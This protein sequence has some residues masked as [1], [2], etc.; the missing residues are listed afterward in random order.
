[1]KLLLISL[2]LL[3][4]SCMMHKQSDHSKALQ[5]FTVKYEKALRNYCCFER[6]WYGG[7]LMHDIKK[8][9]LTYGIITDRHDIAAARITA[10]ECID[11]FTNMINT[12]EK[13]HPYLHEHPF[14]SSSFDL[15]L[16]LRNL[17]GSRYTGEEVKSVIFANGKLY[18]TK[19]NPETGFS[20]DLHEETY[21]EAKRLVEQQ[22][23]QTES[24]KQEPAIRYY[25]LT[26]PSKLAF[27]TK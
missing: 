25:S 3:L 21:E 9:S 2:L 19:Y 17:D 16:S 12:D 6:M 7:A 14:P 10:I 15:S 5:Q 26:E 4:N 8:V 11:L 23:Q 27:F 22:K 18:F 24:K 13:V 20:S 1:M